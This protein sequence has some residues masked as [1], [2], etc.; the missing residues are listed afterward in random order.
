MKQTHFDHVLRLRRGKGRVTLGNIVFVVAVGV[1][2]SF[3]DWD[4]VLGKVSFGTP[5]DV[6]LSSLKN[7]SSC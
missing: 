6:S 4:T 2:A 3:I 7:G 1:V 5:A